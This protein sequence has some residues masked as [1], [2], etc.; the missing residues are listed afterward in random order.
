MRKAKTRAGFEVWNGPEPGD[1]PK[2]SLSVRLSE[3]PSPRSND[4]LNKITR[5]YE[6]R[7]SALR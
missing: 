1:L 2:S 3:S 7:G 6:L 5:K 4:S